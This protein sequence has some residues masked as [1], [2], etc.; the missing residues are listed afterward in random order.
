MALWPSGRTGEIAK[1]NP[2]TGLSDD[3]DIGTSPTSG[4]IPADALV[5]AFRSHGRSALQKLY[6]PEGCSN[7]EVLNAILSEPH[8]EL[9]LRDIGFP[10]D[11]ITYLVELREKVQLRQAAFGQLCCFRVFCFCLICCFLLCGVLI[12]SSFIVLI[13]IF[14]WSFGKCDIMGFAN[15][16]CNQGSRCEFQIRLNAPGN[17]LMTVDRWSPTRVGTAET[18]KTGAQVFAMNGPFKCCNG[19][20]NGAGV[21]CCTLY[22]G[23]AF[24]D[25]W[26]KRPAGVGRGCPQAPWDC[27]YK[28]SDPNSNSLSDF[29]DYTPPPYATLLASGIAAGGCGVLLILGRRYCGTLCRT[30]YRGIEAVVHRVQPLL[31]KMRTPS[32]E[33]EEEAPHVEQPLD[34]A[35]SGMNSSKGMQ[36][37][38]AVEAF[39]GDNALS[40]VEFLDLQEEQMVGAVRDGSTGQGAVAGKA[41]DEVKAERSGTPMAAPRMAWDDDEEERPAQDGALFS[42]T[43][44]SFVQRTLQLM[45]PLMTPLPK[46]T[47]KRHEQRISPKPKVMV[48]TR[49]KH[50]DPLPAPGEQSAKASPHHHRGRGSPGRSSAPKLESRIFEGLA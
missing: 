13:P 46:Q 22:D 10:E 28:M 2:R 3:D 47:R 36:T 32:E 31:A 49:R 44:Q 48:R 27:M 25:R 1:P 5:Q 4:V 24:C 11:Q 7:S 15:R 40:D 45:R 43:S 42:V 21:S 39:E 29:K 17:P 50:K 9:V 18:G 19:V 20:Q 16:T 14:G 30:C 34:K 26:A 37:Q 35:F 41:S 8:L 12:G 38:D 33:D 23:E 6:L